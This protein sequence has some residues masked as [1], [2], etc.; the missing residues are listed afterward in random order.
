MSHLIG[1]NNLNSIH[2]HFDILGN[3]IGLKLH[4]KVKV[5]GINIRKDMDRK[6]RQK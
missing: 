2:N 4:H 3:S 6:N 1:L 5:S